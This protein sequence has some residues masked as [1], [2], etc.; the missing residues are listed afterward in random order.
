MQFEN[1]TLQFDGTWKK[2]DGG[3]GV[4]MGVGLGI[5]PPSL[6]RPM[7]Q[8][9]FVVA[10]PQMAIQVCTR[11]CR[12][13]HKF[14]QIF[15][16]RS[17]GEVGHTQ[18]H[19]RGRR[20]LHFSSLSYFHHFSLPVL[21]QHLFQPYTPRDRRRRGGDGMGSEGVGSRERC[22]KRNLLTVPRNYE[23]ERETTLGSRQIPSY[24][25]VKS[26][27]RNRA[28]IL[29]PLACFVA[30]ASTLY[31]Q[32]RTGRMLLC[33][34]DNPVEAHQLT[35]VCHNY[36]PKIRRSKLIRNCRLF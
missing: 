29:A 15:T 9:A 1:D 27:I 13:L 24:H 35:A 32:Y 23:R 31:T 7:S 22:G 16:F 20:Q 33:C 5:P 30:M 10:N 6:L 36:S 17:F 34:L 19:K 18:T 21:P 28:K 26:M 25:F 4:L 8:L 3:S 14:S 12:R 11:R 2:V